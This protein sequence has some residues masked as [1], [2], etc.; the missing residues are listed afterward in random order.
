MLFF[1]RNISG[2]KKASKLKYVLIDLM[3]LACFGGLFIFYYDKLQQKGKSP[4]YNKSRWI[5]EFGYR[6]KKVAENLNQPIAISFPNDKHHKLKFLFSDLKGAL[7]AVTQSGKVVEILYAKETYQAPQN[8]SVIEGHSGQT[9]LCIAD[10]KY[11]FTTGTIQHNQRMLNRIVRYKFIYNKLVK[12]KEILFTD[13]DAGVGHFIGHCKITKDNRILF[14]IGDALKHASTHDINSS[15]GKVMRLD[16]NLKSPSDNPFY[17]RKSPDNI[18]SM[19]YASGL[20]NPFAISDTPFGIYVADNGSEIDR[21]I[22]LTKGKDFPW[23]GR[24]ASLIYNNL[25]TWPT[26]IGPSDMIYIDKNNLLFPE[27]R[28]HLV[29]VSSY[30][31]ALIAIPIDATLG[32]AGSPVIILH[33]ADS[34]YASVMSPRPPLPPKHSFN[35]L[36][37]GKD[38]IYIT[39]ISSFG[40]PNSGEI[41]K[42]IPSRFRQHKTILSGDAVFDAHQCRGCHQ[43]RGRGSAQAV[44][45]DNIFSTIQKRLQSEGYLQ[46]LSAIENN[47][48]D[49]ASNLRQGIITIIARVNQ[50][51]DSKEIEQAVRLWLKAKIKYPKFSDPKAAMPSINLSDEQ[52]EAVVDELLR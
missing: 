34:P 18:A 46:K 49:E 5:T 29:V 37:L 9:G 48:K 2:N 22:K 41:L 21:L 51:D 35:G 23:D 19:V 31:R 27:L 3:V 4:A 15:L 6:I 12:D 38:G 47:K 44:S 1:K 33:S 30:R 40:E 13:T 7:G 32:V 11:V 26:P 20:R 52:V 50:T 43:I 8:L 14:G 45:L 25:L 17:N 39:H 10:D 42:L 36:A 28:G 16:L 24:N